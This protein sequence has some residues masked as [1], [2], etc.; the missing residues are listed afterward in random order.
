MI[1]DVR[2]EKENTCISDVCNTYLCF[3]L[4]KLNKIYSRIFRLDDL[5]FFIST[6]CSNIENQWYC[7][8]S[9]A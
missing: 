8:H 9:A 4:T 3:S 6:R 5:S 2:C 1:K 7:R